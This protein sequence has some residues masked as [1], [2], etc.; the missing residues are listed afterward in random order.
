MKSFTKHFKS[1]V[2]KRSDNKLE[3]KKLTNIGT[4]KTTKS[5]GC[6]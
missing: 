4:E 2:Y 6:L 5:T 3:G 1:I